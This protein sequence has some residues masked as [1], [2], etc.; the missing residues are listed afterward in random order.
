MHVGHQRKSAARHDVIAP[1]RRRCLF[2]QD[3]RGL[4]HSLSANK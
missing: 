4:I 1:Y 2:L 3:K